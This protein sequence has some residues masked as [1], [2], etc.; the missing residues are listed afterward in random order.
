MP[1]VTSQTCA[2]QLFG[3]F[4]ATVTNFI[5][6]TILGL[7]SDASI[8]GHAVELTA[9]ERVFRWRECHRAYSPRLRQVRRLVVIYYIIEVPIHFSFLGMANVE[10]NALLAQPLE[11]R[12]PLCC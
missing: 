1:R 6:S 7:S 8:I 3:N 11:A 5:L 9:S 4:W 12:L 10:P 2:E